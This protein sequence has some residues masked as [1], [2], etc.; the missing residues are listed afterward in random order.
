MLHG[1]PKLIEMYKTEICVSGPLN[2][3]EH[4]VEENCIGSLVDPDND[5]DW[6]DMAL[7]WAIAKGLSI[8]EAHKFAYHAIAYQLETISLT[9]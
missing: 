7:G 1:D 3:N 6:Q 2:P 8:E 5:C 4:N 9:R